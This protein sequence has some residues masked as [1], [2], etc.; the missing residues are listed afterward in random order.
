MLKKWLRS[1][2]IPRSHYSSTSFGEKPVIMVI[3]S[4]IIVAIITIAI[5]FS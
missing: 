3:T 5:F 2:K 1:L 4:A